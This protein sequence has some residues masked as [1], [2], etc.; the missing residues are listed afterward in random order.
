MVAVR[1]LVGG[2][3]D[4]HLVLLFLTIIVLVSI[5]AYVTTIFIGDLAPSVLIR[6][7][8]QKLC[9]MI[10]AG[11]V[12]MVISFNGLFGL[13]VFMAAIPIGMLPSYMGIKKSHAMGVLL[14][15]VMVHYFGVA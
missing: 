2:I 9:I 10:L 3:L 1:D 4:A 6:F 14:L 8:Y 11:L 13:A 7:D 15:P 12:A 5:A